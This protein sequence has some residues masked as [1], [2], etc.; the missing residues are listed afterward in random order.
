MKIKQFGGIEYANNISEFSEILQN[1]YGD[2]KF[3]IL[4]CLYIFILFF[5]WFDKKM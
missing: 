3:L 5:V 2:T 1:K 4:F